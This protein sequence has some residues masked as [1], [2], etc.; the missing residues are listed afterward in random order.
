MPLMCG[1]RNW[2]LA[3]DGKR[4]A[5]RLIAMVVGV[6]DPVNLRDT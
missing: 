2:Y 3:L 5:L 4:V 6:E 1:H